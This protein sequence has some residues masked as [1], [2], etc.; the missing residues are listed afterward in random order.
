[1]GFGPLRVL[2]EDRLAPGAA[3]PSQRRANM[4]IVSIVLA[5]ALAHRDGSGGEG[6]LHPGDVLWLGAGHGI[7]HAARNPD[8]DQPVHLLQAWLQPDRLNAAPASAQ[9][10]FDPHLRRARWAVL[11]APEGADAALA[12]RLQAW[13][14]ATRLHAGDRVEHPLQAGRRY[15]LQVTAG[16]IEAAGQRLGAGDALGFEDERGPLALVGIGECSDALLFDLPG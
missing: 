12:L 3:Y 8:T 5:G 7:E 1:M 13:L 9:W 16:E 14:R 4:E 2:N 6:V 15:W 10:H 11:A